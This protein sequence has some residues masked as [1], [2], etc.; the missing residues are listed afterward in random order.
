MPLFSYVVVSSSSCE[1]FS[2]QGSVCQAKCIYVLGSR[3]TIV[4]SDSDE[5]LSVQGLVR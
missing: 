5:S 2:A 4:S 3:F 1:S